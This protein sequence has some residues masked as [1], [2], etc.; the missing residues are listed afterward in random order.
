MANSFL[1]KKS[2]LFTV[3]GIHLIFVCFGATQLRPWGRWEKISAVLDYYG[4]LSGA[5]SGYGFFAPRVGSQLQAVFE[6]TDSSG[7]SQTVSLTDGLNREASLRVR[8]LIDWYWNDENNKN[9]QRSLAASWAGKMFARYPSSASVTVRLETYHLP[10]MGE[11]KEG[12]R[13]HWRP[14]Y[15]AKFERQIKRK[16]NKEG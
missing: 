5:N 10:S 6:I 16:V 2:F 4:T 15:R 3:V 14:I 7:K 12:K 1:K 8:K 11:Y 9:L 13:P